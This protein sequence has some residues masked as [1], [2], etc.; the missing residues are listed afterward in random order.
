MVA[1][2]QKSL[3]ERPGLR[4]PAYYPTNNYQTSMSYSGINREMPSQLSTN[5][6]VGNSRIALTAHQKIEKS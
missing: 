1:Y 2:L 4:T 6:N 5:S 3:N